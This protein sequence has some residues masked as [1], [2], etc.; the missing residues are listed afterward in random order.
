MTPALG[1]EE[2]LANIRKSL[3]SLSPAAQSGAPPAPLPVVPMPAAPPLPSPTPQAPE[4]QAQVQD[5]SRQALLEVSRLLASINGP[6]S[7]TPSPTTPWVA[8][9][10]LQNSLM[11]LKRQV[12]AL[13][14][15]HT[16]NTSQASSNSPRVTPTPSTVITATP[17]VSNVLPNIIKN[18][19]QDNSSKEGSTDALLLRPG[20]LAAHVSAEVKE[21]IW[22]GEFVDIFSL[23]RARRREVDAKDQEAKS[24][25]SG[26]RKPKVEENITNWLFGFTV[27]MSVLLEKKPELGTSL[28]YYANKILKAQHTYGGSVWLEYDRDFRW[29]KVEDP[30]IGWDQTEVDVWLECV[31]NKAPG[32]QPFRSQFS[33]E[34][35]GS[36][37]VF[38]RKEWKGN[39]TRLSPGNGERHARR[40]RRQ[41][42]GGVVD[43]SRAGSWRI[44]SFTYVE[45]LCIPCLYNILLATREPVHD[46]DP[47]KNV[48]SSAG[49]AEDLPRNCGRRE[50]RHHAEDRQVR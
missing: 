26:Y 2:V 34:K 28:I 4:Q 8:N 15:A 5:S 38:N 43:D 10:S 44:N 7:N 9:D 24:S 13:A 22:K 49:S 16:S 32:R 36:C 37:W 18:P 27:F 21:E 35:K 39:R 47:V 14:A 40:E 31:N 19:G 50:K 6:A 3:A 20:K 23:I 42:G 1:V 29:T 11:E 25:P 45:N 17:V 33:G 46:P 30:S 41:L 12:D 48:K